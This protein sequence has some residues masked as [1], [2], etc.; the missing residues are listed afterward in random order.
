MLSALVTGSIIRWLLSCRNVP[1]FLKWTQAL[2]RVM[3]CCCSLLTSCLIII[4][5]SL[6]LR[7][8][9]YFC[10]LYCVIVYWSVIS[11]RSVLCDSKGCF[12]LTGT[13]YDLLKKNNS[14]LEAKNQDL[15]LSF[16][17]TISTAPRPWLSVSRAVS[18][19]V[20]LQMRFSNFSGTRGI[21]TH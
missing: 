8:E 6:I 9:V 10:K 19:A 11:V 20:G 3:L 18:W 16:L 1:P 21:L 5:P 2:S 4:Q 14:L 15:V 13:I 7:G 17:L 12:G